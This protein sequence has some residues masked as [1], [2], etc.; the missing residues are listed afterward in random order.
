MGEA[1]KL[2]RYNTGNDKKAFI[3]FKNEFDAVVFNATIVAYSGSSVADLISVH[4]NQ[5][6]IDPQTHIFQHDISAIQTTNK[7]TNITSIKKSVE[8]YLDKLPCSIKS[9]L[10]DENR[11]VI[12][13]DIS[14]NA[15]ELIDC[16]YSFE[17]EFVR[18]FIKDKEYD[19]YLDYVGIESKPRFVIA[20]YFMLKETYTS[21]EVDSWLNVNRICLEKFINKNASRFEVAAQF[22][23]DKN[24]LMSPGFFNKVEKTY[25]IS[26]YENIFL[27]I[28]NFDSFEACSELQIAFFNLLELFNKNGLK[29]IMAYGGY[30]SILLCNS[31]IKNRLYGVAQSV[32]YGE[33]R[34]ITP[35]GGGLPTNKYYF[36][37]IH[38]RLKFDA[39]A[40]ILNQQGYFS[41][42]KSASEY[43]EDYK[44][45]I[46]NCKQCKEII[47]KDINNFNEYNDSIAFHYKGRY[48]DISRNRPTT[49]ANL[50]A[51]MH[52][53]WSKVFEWGG[54]EK[55]TLSDLVKELVNNYKIYMPT[56]LDAIKRWCNIYAK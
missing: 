26:G 51:A 6:I 21:S 41:K 30:D 2:L 55:K 40:F 42:S 22:V 13:T 19:K 14:E 11:S 3:K 31:Q 29:P 1:L 24:T 25:C 15:D 38:R 10:F 45:K 9:I 5:Y 48:G 18:D 49:D 39:A 17:T 12:P 44:E 53:M 32:G 43:A 20:P 23:V 34:P 33:A 36:Y 7:K 4:K 28:D 37:P 50:I 54:I 35:V 16:V 8:K 52:F 27:W 56:E 46:C 47:K